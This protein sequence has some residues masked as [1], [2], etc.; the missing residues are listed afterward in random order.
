MPLLKLSIFYLC[1]FIVGFLLGG[2]SVGFLT[3]CGYT[4]GILIYLII[5]DIKG[6]KK[7]KNK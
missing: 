5:K 2:Q 6:Y 1:L 3:M 7:E 4:T